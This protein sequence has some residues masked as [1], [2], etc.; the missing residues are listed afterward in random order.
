MHIIFL[1]NCQLQALRDIFQ[2][3]IGRREPITFSFINAYEGVTTDA[4]KVLTTADVVVLQHSHRPPVIGRRHVSQAIP[5]HMAPAVSGAFLW[6][7]QGIRHPLRPVARYG[8]NPYPVDYN[9]RFLARLIE[10]HTPPEQA[11]KI[12]KAH[13]VAAET[14]V[15][16]IYLHTL[17]TQKQL[18]AD[19][20]FDTAGIIERYLQEEQLFQAPYHFSGRIARH[21][22][23]TLSRR[24]GFHETYARRIEEYLDDAPFLPMFLPIHPSIARHFGLRWINEDTRYPHLHEGGYTFDEY[25][26]RFMQGKWSAALEEGLIDS[27]RSLPEAKE[28]LIIGLNEAPF[29]ARGHYALACIFERE[30]DLDSAL[31]HLRRAF[32]LQPDYEIAIKLGHFLM[33]ANDLNGA[34]EAYQEAARQDPINSSTWSILR[35]ALLFVGRYEEADIAAAKFLE[36]SQKLE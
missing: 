34:I 23:A 22:A 33:R 1:G 31:T 11:L 20:G 2:R 12:Y 19:C 32:A 7:L 26:L 35:N 27:R 28:K 15:Q 6:P 36:F 13:D 21:L 18:D 17:R 25:V 5:V 16:R 3:F 9:D 4:Y 10:Q 24:M 8:D 29:S 30:G 14:H